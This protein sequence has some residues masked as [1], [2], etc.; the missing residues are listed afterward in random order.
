MTEMERRVATRLANVWNMAQRG[1]TASNDAEIEAWAG[2]ARAVLEEISDPT[3]DMLDAGAEVPI[4]ESVGS[5]WTAMV[6]VA[7]GKPNEKA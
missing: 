1:I 3:Q 2:E 7:R 6:N 4:S 5:V